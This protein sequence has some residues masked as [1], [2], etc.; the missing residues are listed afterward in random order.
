MKLITPHRLLP[1]L[2][3]LA[4]VAAGNKLAHHPATALLQPATIT[5]SASDAML[6]THFVSAQQNIATHAASLIELNGGSVRAFWF[7]G[8]REGARDVEIRSAVFDGKQWSK[9]RGIIDREQTQNALLRYVKKLGN[10]VAARAPDGSIYLYFVTVSLGGWA[11]SSLTSMTSRDEGETWS[12]PRRLI[13]S[14][15]INISTLIKGTPYAYSDGT[16]GLPVYHEFLGKFGELLHL[17]ADSTVLDKQRLSEGKSSIQPVML[18]QDPKQ[19]LVL[20]RYTG[21]PPMRVIS[22]QTNDAGLH[23]SA[24]LKTSLPNPDAAISGTVLNDGR[25]VLVLNNLEQG[26]YALSLMVSSD[27]GKTWHTVYELEKQSGRPIE[28]DEFAR[29]NAQLALHTDAQITDAYAYAKS[30]Q[31]NKCEDGQCGYEFSYP[32]LI[33]THNGDFHLVYTWNRSFIKHVQFSRA[34]LDA[35]IKDSGDAATH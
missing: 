5:P 24:P 17:S 34:W 16:I 25:M 27:S 1:G 29:T 18:V 30:A 2:I 9:E 6:T 33:Q 19:A 35:R 26:R 21:A 28:L 11:G 31:R 10:P 15:F 4:C 14:P 20:M 3:A 8:S 13:T 23:W 12:A 7:A 22:T 32:Y